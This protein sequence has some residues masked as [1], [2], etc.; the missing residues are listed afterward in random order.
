MK[1]CIPLHMGD[2]GMSVN[3]GCSGWRQWRKE[4]S[5]LITQ[6]GAFWS[7]L[8]SSADLLK[9]HQMKYVWTQPNGGQAWDCSH[10]SNL[11]PQLLCTPH[12]R[13][14][15]VI[16][17]EQKKPPALDNGAKSFAVGQKLVVWDRF[18]CAVALACFLSR[19]SEQWN[20]AELHDSQFPLMW[21]LCLVRVSI[22]S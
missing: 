11:V 19:I 18:G 4:P 7:P 8:K 12:V 1:T 5:C 20:G 17:F 21:G 2:L 13:L 16:S 14:L 6:C 22:I 9:G 15:N 3:G 10:F